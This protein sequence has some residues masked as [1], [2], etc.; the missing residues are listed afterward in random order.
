MNFDKD[1]VGA[2]LRGNGM[3]LANEERR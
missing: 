3:D 1:L 2:L